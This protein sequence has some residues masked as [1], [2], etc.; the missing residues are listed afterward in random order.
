MNTT[1][2]RNLS[3]E[4]LIRLGLNSN[5]PLSEALAELADE[6]QEEQVD[7]DRLEELEEHSELLKEVIENKLD[8]LFKERKEQYDDIDSDENTNLIDAHD[9]SAVFEI[10]NER[11]RAE[12][13]SVIDH[14]PDTVLNVPEDD[15]DAFWLH[16]E[17]NVNWSEEICKYQ[18]SYALSSEPLGTIYSASHGETEDELKWYIESVEDDLGIKVPEEITKQLDTSEAHISGDYVY[19]DNTYT[20]VSWV[21]CPKKLSDRYA[22]FLEQLND[23]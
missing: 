23:D 22:E 7:E 18:I 3:N 20:Y 2:I 12:L 13:E 17:E 16:L 8:A 19:F 11:F 10:P 9:Q 1:T 4:E 15:F 6:L 21:L 5:Q 14:Y